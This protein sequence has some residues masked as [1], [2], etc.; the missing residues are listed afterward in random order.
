MAIKGFPCGIC[1]SQ[2]PTLDLVTSR[3]MEKLVNIYLQGAPVEERQ[4]YERRVMVRNV[5][6]CKRSIKS[7]EMGLM[8]D[9]WNEDDLCWKVGRI[10]GLNLHSVLV[11]DSKSKDVFEI[12]IYSRKLASAFFYTTSFSTEK[13]ENPIF[14]FNNQMPAFELN[15][16]PIYGYHPDNFGHLVQEESV[17][18][19]HSSSLEILDMPLPFMPQT[20][21]VPDIPRMPIL[22][23]MPRMPTMPIMPTMPTVPY[24]YNFMPPFQAM[25]F[26][27]SG[28]FRL[29]N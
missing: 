23:T 25:N 4:D 17:Q 28:G 2:K 11:E 12:S 29:A 6:E 3:E 7:F 8:V 5:S 19:E 15:H 16:F 13:I 26:M 9:Y 22:P 18:N 14:P 21:R 1:H 10:Q 20:P 27:G 24:M